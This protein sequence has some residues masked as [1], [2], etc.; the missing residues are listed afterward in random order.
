MSAAGPDQP[1]TYKEARSALNGPF[2]AWGLFGPGAGVVVCVILAIT[3][4]GAWF[5]SILAALLTLSLITVTLLYRN[6]PT[7]L[8]IDASAIRIGAV[9]SGR[10]A[11]RT[12]TVSHQAWGIF[13]CPWSAVQG[14]R[15]VAGQAEVRRL[16]KSPRLYT[17]TNRWGA[18]NEMTVTGCKAGVLTS[19]FM[20][21][22][23]VIDVDPGAVTA[24]P[25][26]PARFYSNG[27]FGRFSTLIRPEL[28]PTWIVPTRHPE[29]LSKALENLAER[30]A[31]ST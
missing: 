22:A 25:I 20:R 4:S 19:P 21:A 26:R 9:R 8:A 3:V 17:L 13:S 12:P 27:K 18:K 24:P 23:L 30:P 1:A 2:L 15:V 31:S 14:I 7:G 5:G 6:W 10:A 28:S 29:N 16:K 11:G